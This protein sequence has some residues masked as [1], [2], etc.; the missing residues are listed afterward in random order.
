MLG[1]DIGAKCRDVG[2][3]VH[4]LLLHGLLPRQVLLREELL[5]VRRERVHLVAQRVEVG[6]KAIGG[7][8]GH[9][10]VVAIHDD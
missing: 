3:H 5:R 7:R 2:V 9:H 1:D 4:G 6:V 10:V 8:G